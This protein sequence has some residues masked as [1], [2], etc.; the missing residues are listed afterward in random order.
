MMKDTC[1]LYLYVEEGRSSKKV[2]EVGPVY[3]SLEKLFAK[4]HS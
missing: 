4:K 2:T 3:T 1:W